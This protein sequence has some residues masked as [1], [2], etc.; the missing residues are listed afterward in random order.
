MKMMP[1]T[2]MLEIGS[3][4]KGT[5]LEAEWIGRLIRCRNCHFYEERRNPVCKLSG[6]RISKEDYCSKARARKK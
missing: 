4:K 1:I 6:I 3:A 2:E 5:A